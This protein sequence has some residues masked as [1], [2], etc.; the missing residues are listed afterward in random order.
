VAKKIDLGAFALHEARRGNVWPLIGRVTAGA[1]LT[2]GEREYI[3]N[4][5]EAAD[6]RRG[7]AHLKR[8]DQF[9][10]TEMFDALVAEGKTPKQAL[11]ETMR[12]RGKKRRSIYYAR[13]ATHQR[14]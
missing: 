3:V 13:R 8:I 6:R 4:Y 11:A 7:K 9:L 2:P 5:L 10:T 12:L 1:V 14:D